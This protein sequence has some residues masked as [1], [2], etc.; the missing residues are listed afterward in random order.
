VRGAQPRGGDGAVEGSARAWARR[1][2]QGAARAGPGFRLRCRSAFGTGEELMLVSVHFIDSG[3]LGLIFF[4]SFP[5]PVSTVRRTSGP[6]GG[7]G[8]VG[9]GS[10]PNL[11]PGCEGFVAVDH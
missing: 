10:S 8:S 5:P 2:R 11:L 1:G 7:L 6:R 9:A 4:F 3:S